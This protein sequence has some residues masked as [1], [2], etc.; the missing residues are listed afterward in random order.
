[1]AAVGLQPD[2]SEKKDLAKRESDADDFSYT[3]SKPGKTD[4]DKAWQL[5]NILLQRMSLRKRTWIIGGAIGAAVAAS[6]IALFLSLLPLK[7]LHI[8]SNLQNRFYASAE[9]AT[10][11]E[12]NVLFSNYIRS[13]VLPASRNCPRQINK[14]CNPIR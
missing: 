1:M 11:K 5:R 6:L 8:V 12:T 2:E 4:G 7:I 10:Q 9:S 14:S 3:G 13:Y